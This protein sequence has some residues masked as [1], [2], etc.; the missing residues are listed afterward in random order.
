MYILA[1]I[2]GGIAVIIVCLQ[3]TPRK[4]DDTD[5]RYRSLYSKAL[6]TIWLIVCLFIL[7][8]EYLPR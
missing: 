1:T 2:T 7:A 5:R 3:L 8:K 4:G 6:A